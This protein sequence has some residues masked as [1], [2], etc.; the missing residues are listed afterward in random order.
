MK[1]ISQKITESN[2]VNKLRLFTYCC[3]I[4]YFLKAEVRKLTNDAKKAIAKKDDATT[5]QSLLVELNQ[6][7][8][9]YIPDAYDYA[10]CD[11]IL[12]EVESQESDSD[13]KYREVCI[14][15]FL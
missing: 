1:Y 8:Y 10:K 9:F 4:S 11:S 6:K 5:I 3:V 2:L 7:K 13:E 15:S 14:C 12:P